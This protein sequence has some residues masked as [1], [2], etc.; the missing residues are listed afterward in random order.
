MRRP[1]EPHKLIAKTFLGLENILAH[2]L[3]SV[4]ATDIVKGK[5]QVQFTADDEV[6]YRANYETRTAI[7]ILKPVA[8]FHASDTDELYKR[9]NE[10][11]WGDYLNPEQKFAVWTTLRS[12]LYKSSKYCSLKVKDSIVDQFRRLYHKRPEFDPENPDVRI[13]LEITDDRCELFLDSSGEPLYMR[14]YRQNPGSG[15]LNEV[16][17]AGIILLSDWNKRNPLVDPM[18]GTGTI[19]IEAAFMAL[20]IPPGKFR[21]SFGFQ[22]WADYKPHIMRKIT[23]AWEKRQQSSCPVLLATAD[24][25][26]LNI[27]QQHIK[28]AHL[29]PYLRPV[30]KNLAE[31][32]EL[33]QNSTLISY[34]FENMK[35]IQ[36]VTTSFLE[37]M[38]R[39]V[40][41]KFSAS[42]TWLLFNSDSQINNSG[43]PVGKKI[44]I[45]DETND[46]IFANMGKK[47]EKQKIFKIERI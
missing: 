27:T 20:D 2:E 21:K 46:Y 18:C 31:W 7:S 19:A 37:T 6:M 12:T 47:N 36:L 38:G 5:K 43:L 9:I 17:A 44:F 34:P 33:P 30:L 45:T 16:L 22:Q 28:N 11:N 15:F 42:N 25:D 41:Q 39:A 4:G 32:K 8:S 24:E 40:Q 3:I 26:R 13:N 14:G 1:V 23:S 35:D 29:T 10:I